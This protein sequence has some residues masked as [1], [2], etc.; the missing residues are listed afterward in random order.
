VR[1]GIR[2][3]KVHQVEAVLA[4]QLAR[5]KWHR[6]ANERAGSTK[7][8]RN[9]DYGAW[10]L[11]ITRWKAAMAHEVDERYVRRQ[12][13]CE[14]LDV[15]LN[16]AQVGVGVAPEGQD[17]ETD[18]VVLKRALPGTRPPFSRRNVPR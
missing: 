11:G 1:H 12:D 2:K 17:S 13:L 14:A 4:V 16:T 5:Y 3:M 15:T 9:T 8:C 18:G 6:W 10:P 7:P